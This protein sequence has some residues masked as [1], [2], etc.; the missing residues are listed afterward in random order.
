MSSEKSSVAPSAARTFMA[1]ESVLETIM[2]ARIT[3]EVIHAVVKDMEKL[4]IQPIWFVDT[5]PTESF[6]TSVVR[7]TSGTVLPHLQKG[8]LK[9]IVAVIRSP[10]LR[11]A[12]RA[13]ALATSVEIKLVESRLEAAPFLS[14][15]A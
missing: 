11:M 8:G 1:R 4:R 13:M 10:G 7:L 12:A 3:E 2:P 14:W 5:G 15:A 6:A 9:R